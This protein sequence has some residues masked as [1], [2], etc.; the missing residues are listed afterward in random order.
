MRS[1]R[2]EIKKELRYNY[3]SLVPCVLKSI[4]ISVSGLWYSPEKTWTLDIL[5]YLPFRNTCNI[6]SN[7]FFL[8]STLPNCACC[9]LIRV[10]VCVC[11]VNPCVIHTGFVK[12]W[13]RDCCR[14]L[15]PHCFVNRL[16]G[17]RSSRGRGR[18]HLLTSAV[19]TLGWLLR[20]FLLKEFSEIVDLKTIREQLVIDGVCIGKNPHAWRWFSVTGGRQDAGNAS[21]S[22]YIHTHTTLITSTTYLLQNVK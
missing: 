19:L 22:N 16:R 10:R 7:F 18:S 21:M 2:D 15:L 11:F 20:R 5:I 17:E 12:L 8:Q 13:W 6:Y 9:R 4:F 3:T 1:I 14:L